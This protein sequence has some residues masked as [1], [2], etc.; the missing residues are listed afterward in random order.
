MSDQPTP[1]KH[2]PNHVSLETRAWYLVVSAMIITYAVAGL[3]VD[4]FY[5]LLPARRGW[6][7]LHLHGLPAWLAGL[8]AFS[9]AATMLSVI[10]DH[11]D[12]R[13]NE[14]GYRRFAKVSFLAAI[15][16]L[17]VAV[18]LHASMVRPVQAIAAGSSW[19][20]IGMLLIAALGAG[21]TAGYMVLG[22]LAT[23]WL[24]P[25]SREPYAWAEWHWLWAFQPTRYAARGQR[26]CGWGRASAVVA[27]VCMLAGLLAARS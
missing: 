3:W 13:Y 12:R 25:P 4:D 18:L 16:L 20:P 8:S 14:S 22:L 9:A 21:A 27:V 24:D 5:V 1:A 6:L 2:T 19:L 15:A 26:L 23:E 7:E 17:I 10:V 11:Y